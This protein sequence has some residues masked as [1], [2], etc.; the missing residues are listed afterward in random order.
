MHY[1]TTMGIAVPELNWVPAPT[2]ILRRA[3]ILDWLR[4][5]PPGRVLEMGC[6]PG[7]LLYDL[8]RMGFT[9]IGVELSEDS[10][11]VAEKLVGDVPGIAI[12]DS[13]PVGQE[14]TFDYLFSFEVLEHIQDDSSALNTWMTYLKPGGV[15]FISVPAHQRRWNVTDIAVGHY[16]RYDRDDVLNLV[17]GAGL[18]VKQLGTYGWPVSR[19]IELL[20]VLAKNRSLRKLDIDPGEIRTGDLELTKASGVDRSAESQL[21]PVY[22]SLVGRFLFRLA[23]LVQKLFYRS[24]LGVSFIVFARKPKLLC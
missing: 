12:R 20:R 24:S 1:T 22:G 3:A 4:G 21:Y 14:G 19:V 16:R 6:G 10:R 5:H 7:A 13:L 18:Q 15:V 9:G 17:R 8:A 2:Y 11:R 23:T